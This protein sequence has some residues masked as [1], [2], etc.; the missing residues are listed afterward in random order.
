MLGLDLTMEARNP[1]TLVCFRNHPR[2]LLK[3]VLLASNPE[4]LMLL[5]VQP[6]DF[7]EDAPGT[8]IF[9]YHIRGTRI[10][11]REVKRGTRNTWCL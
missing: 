6:S 10:V 3:C 2:G 4:P 7:D 11:E 1:Q 8:T 9:R 5:N